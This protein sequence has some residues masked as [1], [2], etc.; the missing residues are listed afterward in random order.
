MKR[1]QRTINNRYITFID[2]IEEK[3][4]VK[5]ETKVEENSEEN[6]E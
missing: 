4:E 1:F 5:N 6:K 3:T 2:L